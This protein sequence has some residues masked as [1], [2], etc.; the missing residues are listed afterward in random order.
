[1]LSKI[2]QKPLLGNR[3]FISQLT[4]KQFSATAETIDPARYKQVHTTDMMLQK[5]YEKDYFTT[6]IKEIE[7]VRSPFF[8]LSQAYEM[9]F[10][11]AG[12]LLDDASLKTAMMDDKYT[13]LM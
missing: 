6:A 9:N 5:F 11:Q 7:F 8:D 1:M 13:S 2:L 12:K 4:V 10:A 3:V